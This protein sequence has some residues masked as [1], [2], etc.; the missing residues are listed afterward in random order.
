MKKYFILIA[1]FGFLC[2]KSS[3]QEVFYPADL[4]WCTHYGEQGELV[5]SA[6]EI[7]SGIIYMAGS[8]NAPVG[9][10]SAGVHQEILLSNTEFDRD[11]F[12][13]A[14]NL[15]GV[16]LWGTYFGGVGSDWIQDMELD[17]QG[18]LI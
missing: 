7:R 11:G 9:V 2:T 12:L 17:A 8:T 6:A 13:A 4:V 5:P 1:A 14:F 10:S 16:F 15:D 18:N 3:A